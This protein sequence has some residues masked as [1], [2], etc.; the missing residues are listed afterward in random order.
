MAK[1]PSMKDKKN[2]NNVQQCSCYHCFKAFS[3]CEIKEWKEKFEIALCPFCGKDT[4]M[5]GKVS[6]AYL[7]QKH[8]RFFE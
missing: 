4:V 6:S 8:S 2:F 1:K 7:T 5:F 3:A